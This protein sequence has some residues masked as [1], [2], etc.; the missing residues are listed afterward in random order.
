MGPLDSLEKTLV[1]V[2]KGLPKLP[3]N[4]KKILADIAPWAALLGAILSLWSAW[5][6]WDW[7]HAVN[8][9]AKWA[10]ELNAAFGTGQQVAVNRL[11]VGVWI[12]LV[13]L[14]IEAVIMLVAFPSLRKYAKAGWNLM[15]ILSLINLVY[16]VVMLFT[17]YGGVGSLFGAL[18]GTAIGWYILFQIR[19]I[20]IT[21]HKKVETKTE[22]E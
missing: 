16:G 13:V 2:S 6:L 3:K 8:N 17:D 11:T 20:Y 19:E 7:A 1:D 10:N 9:L 12:A 15:F 5:A 18:I 14:I 4:I 22:K 21:G